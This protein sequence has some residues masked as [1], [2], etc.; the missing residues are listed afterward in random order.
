MPTKVKQDA[1]GSVLAATGEIGCAVVYL[2]HVY[3]PSSESSGLPS[4]G[5][6]RD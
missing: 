3:D 4:V 5:C 2:V 1:V 6:S